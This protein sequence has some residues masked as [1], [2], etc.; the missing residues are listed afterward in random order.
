M[1][2][3]TESVSVT[4]RVNADNNYRILVSIVDAVHRSSNLNE[5]YEAALDLVVEVDKVDLAAVYLVDEQT[6]EAV[7]QSHR[8]FPSNYVKSA[9]RIASP[10]GITWKIINSKKIINIPD[11]QK[12]NDIGHAG[13][14]A[15]F[16]GLLGIP[17]FFHDEAIGVIWF[18]RYEEEKFSDQDVELLCTIGS[19]IAIAISKAKQTQQLEEMNR[20]LF[21]LSRISQKVHQSTDLLLIYHTFLDLTRELDLFDMMSLYLVEGMSDFRRAVLQVHKG[22]PDEYLNNAS[23]ITYP[24]GLTWKVIESGEHHYYENMSDMSDVMGPA[25]IA[26]HPRTL[27]SAPLKF[28]NQ[29][30]GAIHFMSLKKNA[31]TTEERDFLISLK[32]QIGTAIARAKVFAEAKERTQELQ[33]L[34][35][36]LRST[37]NQLIQSEKLVSLGQLVSSIAHEINNPLTPILGYSQMLITQ[38]D[39]ED[40]KRLRFLEIINQSADKV[41]NIVENLLSFARKDKPSRDYSDV[42]QILSQAVEF[43]EYQLRLEN[44]NIEMTLDPELP[45][46]MVDS[47]QLQQVF[48]NI[49]LNADQA[50]TNSKNGGGTLEILSRRAPSDKIEIVFADNGPGMDTEVQ[51]KIFDPFF[52][53]KPTGIGTG[54]GL[55]VSY[56]I[57]KEHGGDIIVESKEGVGTSFTVVIPILTYKDYITEEEFKQKAPKP[58]YYATKGDKVLIVEDEELVVTLMKGILEADGYSV[59]L[60]DNGENALKLIE[61]GDFR[62]IV[63]DI[64][65]P[66]MNGKEFFGRVKS[67][68]DDLAGR[69]VFITGD[70]SAETLRFIEETGNK[71]LAKPFKI[72]DFKRTIMSVQ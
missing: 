18:G 4:D 54:L 42:N 20:N 59:A 51:L 14:S 29:T 30:I 32:N 22:L 49:I 23:S 37:Q 71:Y 58:T 56:G 38:N 47:N 72:E 67:K 3:K 5:I 21:V 65:M 10:K 62:F 25:G 44:I 60:A 27:F 6:N 28:G 50:M 9:S 43:R 39:M 2:E 13:K 31:Y 48:T 53:T 61:Q 1:K 7:L 55:S 19:H 63:C 17:I 69:I 35:E 34:Y 15:G 52:T 41:K 36:N 11:I 24:E 8:N 68:N 26:L 33:E 57:V 40:D 70:P 16:H 46:T 12:D 64:K 45:L 66:Q